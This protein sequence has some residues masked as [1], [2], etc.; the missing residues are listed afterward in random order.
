MVGTPDYRPDLLTVEEWAE[1]LHEAP[2]R[3]FRLWGPSG[4]EISSRGPHPRSGALKRSLGRL[5]VGNQAPLPHPPREPASFHGLWAGQ[6]GPSRGGSV[7]RQKNQEIVGAGSIT[8]DT[9][10]RR[11]QRPKEGRI[12]CPPQRLR[13]SV[14]ARS[15]GG[16]TLLPG[17]RRAFPRPLNGYPRA[18]LL[19]RREPPFAGRAARIDDLLQAVP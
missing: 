7:L 16:S 18:K 13:G 12:R 10:N 4:P 5:G 11:E 9:G 2:L 8:V 17:R 1:S 19:R 15:P 14:K 3:P 6:E